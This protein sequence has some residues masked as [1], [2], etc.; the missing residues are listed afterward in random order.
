MISLTFLS[1]SKHGPLAISIMARPLLHKSFTGVSVHTNTPNHHTTI[2]LHSLSDKFTPSLV[3]YRKDF[4]NY[5]SLECR[6]VVWQKLA[7]V[8]YEPSAS[9]HLKKKANHNSYK[10]H[11]NKKFQ[12]QQRVF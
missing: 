2:K 1:P 8:S 3:H 7:K 5:G 10:G 11:T 12:Y 4:M 6:R 9:T